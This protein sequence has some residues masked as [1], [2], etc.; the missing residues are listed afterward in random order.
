MSWGREDQP[1]LAV[2]RLLDAA[3][4]AFAEVGL[5]RTRMEHVARYAAC[6]RGTLYRYFPD[7][8]SLRR[9]YVHR[10]TLRM[11]E[12]MLSHLENIA[13]PERAL[14]DAIVFAVGE[15]RGNAVLRAWFVPE[16]AGTTSAMAAG[17]EVIR[18]LAASLL[19]RIFD[20]AAARGRLRRGLDRSEATEWVVRVVLSLLT[21]D[22]MKRDEAQEKA[23][24]R[25]F[26]VPALFD[27]SPLKGRRS[28]R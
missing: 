10:E 24:L 9:G 15:V 17:S 18:D 4:R 7:R 12:R 20:Q 28:S 13:D 22:M 19:D 11:G 8:D 3:G 25:R 23:F 26:L 5:T 2:D 14:V 1:D 16:A 6:S 27:P 21:V